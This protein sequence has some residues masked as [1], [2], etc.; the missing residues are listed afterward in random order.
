MRRRR[1]TNRDL[2]G[3]GELRF[4][5]VYVSILCFCGR[6]GKSVSGIAVSG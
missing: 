2:A 6:E 1:K 4:E 3:A 5:G